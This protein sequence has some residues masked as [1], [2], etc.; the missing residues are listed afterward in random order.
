[1]SDT[2]RTWARLGRKTNAVAAGATLTLALP[3]PAQAYVGENVL[4]SKQ[5]GRCLDSNWSG[6]VYTLP[7]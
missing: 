2:R 3:S 5:T 4:S 6:A 7:C 1:M